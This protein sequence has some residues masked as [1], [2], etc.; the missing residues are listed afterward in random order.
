MNTPHQIRWI[1]NTTIKQTAKPDGSSRTISHRSISWIGFSIIIAL[2]ATYFVWPRDKNF[3]Y[4]TSVP[5][6]VI[7]ETVTPELLARCQADDNCMDIL[8]IDDI[9][10]IDQ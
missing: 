4:A 3:I 6:A 8:S 7:Y 2:M 10:N 1:N 9:N 5:Y